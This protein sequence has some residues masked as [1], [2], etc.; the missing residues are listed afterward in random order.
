[1]A[2]GWFAGHDAPIIQKKL[3]DVQ[4]VEARR[5]LPIVRDVQQAAIEVHGLQLFRGRT[6]VWGLD[7]NR[8]DTV[9]APHCVGLT[10]FA[11]NPLRAAGGV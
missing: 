10:P 3:S 4:Y 6:E 9:Y 7:G 8:L 2:R 11:V 5:R 1:M